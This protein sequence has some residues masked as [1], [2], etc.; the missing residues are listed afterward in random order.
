MYTLNHFAVFV[1]FLKTSRNSFSHVHLYFFPLFRYKKE[2]YVP[3]RSFVLHLFSSVPHSL[4]KQRNPQIAEHV[5]TAKST[6]VDSSFLWLGDSYCK[7]HFTC[8]K[9]THDWT[10]RYPRIFFPSD[11][12]EKV[13][14]ERAQAMYFW[15]KIQ[16][17]YLML[18][19]LFKRS[20]IKG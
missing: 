5:L 14:R 4:A 16:K 7:V 2:M 15:W 11:I 3:F 13:P 9:D 17:Q 19:R 10:R 12:R 1:L 20:E 18:I 6:V 8:I